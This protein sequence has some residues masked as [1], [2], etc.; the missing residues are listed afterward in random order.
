MQGQGITRRSSRLQGAHAVRIVS[1]LLIASLWFGAGCGQDA[2]NVDVVLVT[3]LVPGQEFASVQVDQLAARSNGSREVLAT[4]EARAFGT[5]DYAHGH[6]VASFSLPFG[7]ADLRVRLLRATGRVLAVQ[8]IQASI[9][10]DTIVRVHITRDCAGVECPNAGGPVENTMCLNGQCVD[11]RCSVTAREFCSAISFCAAAPDCGELASCATALCDEGVCIASAIEG[12]CAPAEWCDP[13]P[14]DGC[15]P[16]VAESIDC[17]TI[18]SVD[19]GECRAS[20]W[21]CDDAE[22]VCAPLF[23]LATGSPCGTS[24][25]CDPIGMCVACTEGVACT[26]GC[27]EGVT[28]CSTGAV[29]C[30]LNVPPTYVAIGTACRDVGI[31]V[32]G[33]TC[34]TNGVCDALHRCSGASTD[35]GI[36]L[37]PTTGLVT[38]ENGATDSIDVRLASPPTAN[39]FVTV[40]SL[41]TSEGTIAPA[42]LAFTPTNWD[43]PQ[44]LTITGVDDLVADGD[45]E[46][47]IHVAIASGDTRYAALVVDD[48]LVS[49]LD[50]D[51]AHVLATPLSGLTTTEALGTATFTLVLTSLPTADVTV[52]LA[53]SDTTEGNVSPSSVRFTPSNWNVP[54]TIT[55]TGINDSIADGDVAYLIVTSPAVST[56][57]EY[58]GL[59]GSDVSVTNLDNDSAGITVTPTGGLMTTEGG[60]TATFS[61]VLTS[62]PTSTVMIPVASNDT[63]E[64]TASPSSLTFSAANWNLP[65]TVTV[66]GADDGIFDGSVNYLVV[67]SP[68]TSG[69]PVYSGFDADDVS[70]TNADND[71]PGVLVTPTTGLITSESGT[72]ATFTMRLLLAPSA[73]VSVGLSSSNTGE[74]TVVPASVTFT[75]GNWNV[76]QTVT[77]TGVNDFALDGFIPYTIVTT[78]TTSADSTYNSLPV[79]DVTVVNQNIFTFV[80][81]SNSEAADLFGTAISVSADGTVLAVSAAGE[82]SSATGVNGNQANNAAGSSGAVY[83]FR[84]TA[85]VW[86][87]E[88]YIKPSNTD[89]DDNF[90]TRIA[91]SS[92]GTTL[93]VGSASEA[94]NATGID[95][96]QT[97]NSSY[98]AGA[99]YVFRRVA[100]SWMQEA[101]VKASNTRLDFARFGISLAISSDGNRLAVGA[102]DERSNAT[103]I[104]G[105]QMD[106]SLPNAGAVYV[107]RRTS[108]TWSQEAYVKASN[109]GGSDSFGWYLAMSSDGDTLAVSALGESSSATGINGNQAD[110]SAAFSGAA[111]VFRYASMAWSQEAYIKA[112]NTASNDYFAN[113]L[114]LS[115]DGD[116]LAVSAHNE[117]GSATGINGTD[118]NAATSAGAA[119][120]FHRAAGVWSQT[121]YVKASNTDANDHFGWM[122]ALSGDGD[123]LAVGST[124]EASNG[125]S[126]NADQSDNSLMYA[127]A[128]YM[129]TRTAGVWSQLAFVKAPNTDSND[130]FGGAIAL[131]NDGMRW[132][133]GSSGESS[134]S[135]GVGGNLLDNGATSSGA[136]FIY[137][138]D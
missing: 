24:R 25:V 115:A 8:R 54:R 13:D 30:R 129:F 79:S 86:S 130:S 48:V 20:S 101:Y 76:P 92:D 61:V 106:S 42:V 131:T 59:D 7:R 74:G 100:G 39:V 58:S 43:E 33:Q 27:D 104:N 26:L 21:N 109:T 97:D 3:G 134:G 91:L 34:I 111:Y 125:F 1:C 41:D 108:G 14:A 40:S 82:D 119:Y 138:R 80:K 126:I 117:S 19:R 68:A 44:T 112:S 85:G 116:T 123:T 64:G 37:E 132:F 128:V 102:C 133:I 38:V 124:R 110:N 56:D 81:S 2:A 11:P 51:G 55:I 62:Q 47:A 16:R 65:R 105:D 29:T 15:V 78:A 113:T 4:S 18:C 70:V 83:I 12:A 137:E 90:G 23:S 66:T 10:G 118:N 95:G 32:E 75:T 127:G 122:V 67:T 84:L 52:A 22:P 36:V 69:D 72:S 136:I 89:A 57:V 45:Q 87:Q 5:T 73:D 93:A 120:L 77:V 107:F 88:A 135:R 103:G 71:L 121:A 46:Y 96:N 60:G 49:N 50:D 53:S 63:T 6:R 94:S 98:H 35:P 9:A 28:E 99:A 31:C 114:A 17:G